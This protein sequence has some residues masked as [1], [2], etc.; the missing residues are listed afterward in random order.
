MRK[1]P[2]INRGK[3]GHLPARQ[4]VDTL[5]QRHPN[6]RLMWAENIKRW[7]LVQVDRD[8][9]FLLRV[10]QDKRGRFMHPN[11]SNSVYL[12][13][14][15]HPR[16]FRH[17]FQQDRFLKSIDDVKENRDVE[18]RSRDA[19]REGSSE[20]FKAMTSRKVI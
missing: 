12:L 4:V 3:V 20:L 15:M 5:R 17:F 7:C 2:T 1:L 14:R 13:D 9:V 10:L 18:R 19:I 8:P 16:N 11:L 6:V